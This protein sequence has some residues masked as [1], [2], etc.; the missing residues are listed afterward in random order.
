MIFKIHNYTYNGTNYRTDC[1]GQI[2]EVWGPFVVYV[3]EHDT[4][5]IDFLPAQFFYQKCDV[6]SK[7]FN[8]TFP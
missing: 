7:Y 2:I 3:D 4:K 6:R 5:K 1:D 8:L